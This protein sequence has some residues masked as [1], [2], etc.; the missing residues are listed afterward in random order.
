MSKLGFS[1]TP[2]GVTNPWLAV[3]RFVTLAMDNCL[4]GPGKI[5]V[6]RM[7]L[8]R[9]DHSHLEQ[10]GAIFNEAIQNST[11][12]YEYKPRT[13][14]VMAAW[15]QAKLRGNFP[16]IG[17]VTEAGELAGFGTYGLFRT[18]AAYKYTVE[19]SVYVATPYRRQ[20]LGKRLLTEVIQAAQAQN[21]H[22][23]VGVIDAANAVSIR[24]H[25]AF[26]FSHAGTVREVGFKFGGWLDVVF[27]QKVLS[28]PDAPIG[29]CPSL[30]R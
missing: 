30:T 6:S 15:H 7:K 9:C 16:I 8:I 1:F 3:T 17:L 27:Y 25:E 2:P 22:V 20:G 26:G 4:T 14:E 11:A 21:F 13:P 24:M 10:I 29:D 23:L 19:H 28:T 5:L 18:A 12:L